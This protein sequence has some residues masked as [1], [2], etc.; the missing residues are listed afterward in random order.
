MQMPREQ[1]SV[2]L[3]DDEELILETLGDY[4]A[5]RGFNVFLAKGGA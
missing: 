1:L 4:M 5:E 3:I 2:L